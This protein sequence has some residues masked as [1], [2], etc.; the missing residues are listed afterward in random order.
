MIPTKE[1]LVGTWISKD[2]PNYHYEDG[3]EFT[4]H[5]GKYAT[6]YYSKGKNMVI[7]EGI[8]KVVEMEKENFNI[9]VDGRI[10]DLQ[11]TI[12]N[13]KLYIKQKPP[14]F[15]MLVPEKGARYFEKLQ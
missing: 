1:E 6:L 3:L 2:F 13:S 12:L 4:F 10:I 7:A 9:I 14:S 8:Y 5:F 15:V 11:K